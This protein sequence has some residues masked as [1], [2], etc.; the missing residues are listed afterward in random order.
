MADQTEHS[1][2]RGRTP[3]EV[4]ADNATAS[5]SSGPPPTRLAAEG[6][7]AG[8]LERAETGGGAPSPTWTTCASAM[9][10]SWTRERADGTVQGGRRV[11]ARRGQPRTGDSAHAG[12]ESRRGRQTDV[13]SSSS[14][15]RVQ[16][17]EHLGYARDD[18]GRGALRPGAVTRWWDRGGPSRTGAR[19]RWSRCCGRA[20]AEGSGQAAAGRRGGQ[21]TRG[22]RSAVATRLL[23]GPGG[24]PGRRPP[25]EIQQAYPQAGPHVSPGRQ[26]GSGRRR[27]LQGDQR[28]LHVLSDPGTRQ[29]YDRFGPDFR[30]VP[31]DS[32][33]SGLGAGCGAGFRGAAGRLRRAGAATARTSAG[34]QRRRHRHRRPLRRHVRRQWRIRA[35]SGRRPGGGLELTVEEAYRRRQ[36]HHPAR[37]RLAAATTSPF[38]AG[39]IDGQRV[40]LAGEGGRGRGAGRP[41]TS[42][43][44]SAS[45]RTPASGSTDATSPS[46]SCVAL[47]GGAGGRGG[48]RKARRAR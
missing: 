10:A 27:T 22:V 17:L 37:P 48:G 9:P 38:P 39:V 11:A 47:G 23:R 25:T 13:R 7:R 12:A 26:Q 18:A 28:G 43:W 44:W 1:N 33:R 35:D 24:G 3:P 6:R 14:T 46:I 40:R 41:E 5:D 30:Q 19:A 36:P 34:L 31:E 32:G 45:P 8:K 2:D 15:K 16:V 20:T 21:P 42:T 29:R 4:R